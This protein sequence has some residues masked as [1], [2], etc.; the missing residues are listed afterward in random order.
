[1][2]IDTTVLLSPVVQKDDM[3][4]TYDGSIQLIMGPMFSGKTTELIRLI[5]RFTVSKK[6]TVILKYTKDVRYGEVNEAVSHDQEKWEA[7]P[8][9]ELMPCVKEALHYDVIGI[10]EGQFF[11]DL[12][13]FSELMADYGKRVIIAALDGTFQRK[14]FGQ[15]TDIVPLCESVRKLRAVCVF[16]GNKASFSMRTTEEESV[17]V[18]G[19]AEKYCAVCRKCYHDKCVFPQ[20]RKINDFIE[21]SE[22]RKRKDHE[23]L[24]QWSSLIIPSAICEDSQTA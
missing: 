24:D 21:P 3:K 22:K 1:M 16:C 4:K 7:I 5:K 12:L 20:T 11:P 13:E 6:R 23:K 17:E 14:V 10:D 2:E 8:T 9:M 19:G 15:I 18:I